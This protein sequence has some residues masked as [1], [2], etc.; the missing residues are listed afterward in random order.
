MIILSQQR[1]VLTTPPKTGST[2]VHATLCAVGGIYVIGPQADGRVDK[3]TIDVPLQAH[4]YGQYILV[5]D[6]YDRAKSLY[7]HYCIYNHAPM[8][9]DDWIDTVLLA[10][11][12]PFNQSISEY[13]SESPIDYNYWKLE[14]LASALRQFEI[15]ANITWLN[16]GLGAPLTDD[17]RKRIEPWAKDDEKRFDY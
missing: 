7:S 6:P 4:S 2:T 16:S 8:P 11:V 9:L 17:Q 14:F 10:G 5:R 15:D 12:E 1:L 13:L 3:H